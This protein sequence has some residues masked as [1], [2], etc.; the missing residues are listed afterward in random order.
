M[1]LSEKLARG[2]ANALKA[3]SFQIEKRLLQESPEI[4]LYCPETRAYPLQ[5]KE[6]NNSPSVLYWKG[7]E[8]IADRPCLAFVGSR[9]CTAYGKKQTKRIIHELAQVNPE[10]V[11]VSGLLARGIDTVAHESA[12]E[13]GLNTVAVLSGGLKQIYISENFD[14]ARIIDKEGSSGF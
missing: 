7:T 1:G 10:L 14:L 6:I 12:L 13:A 11:I 2:I 9:T 5:L 4:H 3:S 8:R